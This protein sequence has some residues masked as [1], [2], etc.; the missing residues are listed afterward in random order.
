MSHRV[1]DSTIIERHGTAPPSRCG[2]PHPRACCARPL[3][4]AYR[5][6]AQR[7]RGRSPPGRGARPMPHHG[8][9]RLQSRRARR[10]ACIPRPALPR[11]AHSIHPT[12][13]FPPPPHPRVCGRQQAATWGPPHGTPGPR[14]LQ[15]RVVTRRP[16]HTSCSRRA[17]PQPPPGLAGA[18]TPRSAAPSL[19][20]IAARSAH[21]SRQLLVQPPA[22]A[23]PP[24]SPLSEPARQTCAHKASPPGARLARASSGVRGRTRAAHVRPAHRAVGQLRRA[25]AQALERAS[26]RSPLV[27]SHA[28]CPAV[29]PPPP[30][31]VEAHMRR[32]LLAAWRAAQRHAGCHREASAHA[33]AERQRC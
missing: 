28:K 3:Q 30:I 23:R 4:W 2:P 19:P 9:G 1:R 31:D 25:Q 32:Q 14:S 12:P 11:R 8:S 7:Q 16:A 17:W 13:P 6:R 24:C 21:H 26:P 20:Q 27:S 5:V 33:C 10:C 18:L 29:L 15:Q 22:A